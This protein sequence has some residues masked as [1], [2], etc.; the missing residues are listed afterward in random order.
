M[1]SVKEV[2]EVHQILI[3]Q[4]GGTSGIRD[5]NG[6]ASALA[7]PFQTFDGKELYPD[8]VS[9]AACLIQSILSNHPFIDGNKRTGYVLMRLFL[10]SMRLDI[11][12]TQEEKYHFVI[13]IASG[14]STFEEIL[15]WITDHL[16]LPEK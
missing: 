14:K 16:S 7:R 6:L 3:L 8:P 10:N 9:K 5:N 12:A 1:I 15:A 2:E 13:N 11:S 4:F